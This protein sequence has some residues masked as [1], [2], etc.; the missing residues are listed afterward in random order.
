MTS[1][2]GKLGSL[3]LLFALIL[4]IS[5]ISGNDETAFFQKISTTTTRPTTTTTTTTKQ[6][7]TQEKKCGLLNDK[8]C[9][10][11]TECAETVRNIRKVIIDLGEPP[12]SICHYLETCCL[13]KD[14]LKVSINREHTAG[15]NQC[16]V[17]NVDGLY[18]TVKG[19][20]LVTSFG[21]YPWVVAIFDVA[22]QFVCTGTLI[23]YNVVLTTASCVAAEQQLIARAGEWD[24]MTENE[25]VAHVNISVKKSI[26]HEKFDWESMEYNIALLILE[27]AFDHLQYITPICLLGNDTEV[28]YEKCFITG[29]RSTRPLN[30]PSRNIVVKVEIAIDSGSCSL[31]SISTEICA[32]ANTNLAIYAKGAPL[33]C[34][35]DS[36][37]YHII[38]A[39]STRTKGVIQF[40]D[41]RQFGPW[42]REKL[43]PD[44]IFI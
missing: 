44:G 37:I 42:I 2:T 34:P 33:I 36:S 35:T 11:R 9:V 27:S 6:P 7:V 14:K 13:P 39:W 29:W 18:M 3:L 5:D 8:I 12:K 17:T 24:L 1:P 19:G 16:G 26:V 43:E 15:S 40:S 41:V 23:A 20:S 28:F 10:K 30:Q 38:G 32:T 25:P 21:E 31:N 4:L 22:A